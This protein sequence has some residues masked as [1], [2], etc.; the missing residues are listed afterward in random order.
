MSRRVQ[1]R[2]RHRDVFSPSGLASVTVRQTTKR[3]TKT[4]TGTTGTL[5]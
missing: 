3:T 5:R 2:A 4:A 1:F